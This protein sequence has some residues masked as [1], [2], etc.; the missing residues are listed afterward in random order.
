MLQRPQD[1]DMRA[2]VEATLEA[3]SIADPKHA[4]CVMRVRA[5]HVQAF[6]IQEWRDEWEA[7]QR[8]M[9]ARGITPPE[10]PHYDLHFPDPGDGIP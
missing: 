3:W 4:Y 6:N 1:S 9:R 7:E 5:S 8:A 2:H 10:W